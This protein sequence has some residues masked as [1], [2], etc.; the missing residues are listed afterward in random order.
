MDGYEV[1]R[2]LRALALTSVAGLVA[3]YWVAVPGERV[4]M[5]LVQRSLVGVEVALLAVLAVQLYQVAA[6]GRKDLL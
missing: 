2:R 1:A 5:G 3:L 6:A 4:M